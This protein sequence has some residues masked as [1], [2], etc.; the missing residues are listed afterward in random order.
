[1]ENP[2][3]ETIIESRPRE[4]A[5]MPIRRVLPAMARRLVGPF[6]FLDHM[7]PTERAPGHG[8]DVRPHPHISLATVTYLFEGEFLHRDSLGSEQRI[9]P[10]DVNWMV[11]GKGIVHS[12]RSPEDARAS[13]GPIHGI[14]SWV[15]LPI[16]EEEREPSFEHVA[17]SALPLLTKRGVEL[18][19]IAGTAYER[20]APTR[21]LSPT[22]YVHARFETGGEL[23]IDD[24]H[25]ER[26]LYAAEGAFDCEGVTFGVGTLLVLRT[27]AQATV[28]A[29][30]G[31]HLMIVGGAPIDGSR[32]IYWNFVSSSKDRIER[33]KSDWRNGRFPKVPGDDKESIPL[34]D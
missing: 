25:A 15:A 34:P 13:G 28:R 26:A 3:I 4:L 18:R 12:E 8:V 21:V 31:G 32:H 20:T 2:A 10:G 22:L 17:K 23:A 24:S 16:A 1:M 33:A 29:R 19:V 14:Q 27:G 5:G 11:A 6:I 9:R 30:A 7:G